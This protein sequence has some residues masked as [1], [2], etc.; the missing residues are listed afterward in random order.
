MF[1]Y[2]RHKLKRLK[3]PDITFNNTVIPRPCTAT[4][5]ESLTASDILRCFNPDGTP[6]ESAQLSPIPAVSDMQTL[7]LNVTIAYVHMHMHCSHHVLPQ[8]S[9]MDKLCLWTF[10]EEGELHTLCSLWHCCSESTRQCTLH[11]KRSSPTGEGQ[12]AAMCPLGA[13]GFYHGVK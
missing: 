5:S 8:M 2:G 4:D 9:N 1:Q 7:P 13:Q 6:L 3:T 12:L 10:P 11:M